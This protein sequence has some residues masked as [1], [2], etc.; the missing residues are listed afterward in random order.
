M[1]RI[2]DKILKQADTNSRWYAWSKL[3]YIASKVVID[4]D[5]K[6]AEQLIPNPVKYYETHA[7]ILIDRFDDEGKNVEITLVAADEFK[8]LGSSFN[9]LNYMVLVHYTGS[10][11]DEEAVGMLVRKNLQ[12]RKLKQVQNNNVGAM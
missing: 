6:K 11:K 9:A 7:T 3:E 5:T 10:G 1:G 8:K 2:A 12:Q 4:K